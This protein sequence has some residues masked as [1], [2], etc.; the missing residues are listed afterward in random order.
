MTL[1]GSE[2]GF[3]VREDSGIGPGGVVIHHH[4]TSDQMWGL[5]DAGGN[6][7][8]RFFTKLM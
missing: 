4:R 1:L 2:K 7:P 8:S 3:V 5:E 6:L